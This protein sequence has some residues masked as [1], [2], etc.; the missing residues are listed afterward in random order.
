MP[1]RIATSPFATKAVLTALAMLLTMAAISFHLALQTERD[2][3]FAD[4]HAFYVAGSL[5]LEGRAGDAYHMATMEQ[6]QHL[7]T[8]VDDFMPWTYPPPYTLLVTALAALPLGLAYALFMALTLTAYVLVLRRIAGDHL[9]GVLIAMLP[10]MTLTVMTGQNGFLTGALTGWFLLSFMARRPQAGWPLGLMILKPHLAAGIAL[11]ALIERRWQA[12]A[13]AAAVVVT[14]LLVPTWVFGA[15]IWSAFLDGVA[16]SGEFLTQGHY[17]LFRMTSLYAMTLST[18]LPS[19]A[20]FAVQAAG[21][22]LALGLL[23]LGWRRGLPP[24]WLAASACAASVFVS[25]YNY[26]YDLGILGV[27]LAFVLPDLLQRTRTAEQIGLLA[28]GWT[29]IG[30]GLITAFLADPDMAGAGDTPPSL[31]AAPLMLLI[32]LVAMTLRRAPLAEPAG[33]VSVQRHEWSVTR[34]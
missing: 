6:A 1:P 12:M 18:G 27:G 30:Y 14:A 2:G 8:G 17:P 25:P 26:D 10:V 11:L 13:I 7:F 34:Y 31:M 19:G 28:V 33:A 23:L 15:G 5:A 9:P 22:L 21:A 4:F 24:R 3:I 29:A 32:A 16:E 20:A